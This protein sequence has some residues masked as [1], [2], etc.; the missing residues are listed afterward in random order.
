MKRPVGAF[1]N[2]WTPW[3]H[4]RLVEDGWNLANRSNGETSDVRVYKYC[5]LC[6]DSDIELDDTPCYEG[7]VRDQAPGDVEM[8]G[9]GAGAAEGQAH[10]PRRRG[11]GGGW[12]RRR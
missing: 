11:D 2:A 1:L 6:R 9:D 10:P 3:S 12:G 5:T 4:E 7:F 8:G